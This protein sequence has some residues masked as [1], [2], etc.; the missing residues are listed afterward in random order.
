[1]PITT[2]GS[3]ITTYDE[4]LAHWEDVNLALGG[5][6]ATDLTLQGLYTRANMITDRAT[7]QA[8]ITLL[9][10]RENDRQIAANSRDVQKDELRDRLGQFRGMLKGKL[11]GT[12]YLAAAPKM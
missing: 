8:A 12:A 6:P 1:M 2:I 4:F 9:E 3:Y 10:D 11:P 7:L 5:T